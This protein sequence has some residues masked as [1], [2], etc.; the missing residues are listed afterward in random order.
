[1]Q[2]GCRVVSLWGWELLLQYVVVLFLRQCFPEQG[3][4]E[5]Y[6]SFRY[7]IVRLE[8][9]QRL[10]LCQFLP[11]QIGVLV[12]CLRFVVLVRLVPGLLIDTS[13]YSFCELCPK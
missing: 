11:N 2:K 1:M 8:Y 13:C 7:W 4:E 6:L 12:L 3:C 9:R 5:S 10:L